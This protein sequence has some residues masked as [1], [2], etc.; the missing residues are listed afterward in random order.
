MDKLIHV[1]LSS[2]R[3]TSLSQRTT[4]ANLANVETVGFRAD[5]T[6]NFQAA[7]LA[8]AGEPTS[9]V[10]STAAP[11]SVSTRGG[12]LE[13]TGN[14]LDVAIN[15][16][17][18]L[19]VQAPDGSRVITRRGDLR[20]GPDQQLVNGSGEIVI[21]DNGPIVVPPYREISITNDGTVNI[22]PIDAEADAP[23]QSIGRLGLVAQPRGLRRR[24]DGNIEA[25]DGQ[26][27]PFDPSITVMSG[28]LER[29]NV[30]SVEVLGKMVELS[31][32]F[33]AQTKLLKTASNM[34]EI[35]TTLMRLPD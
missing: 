21:G 27:P 8:A 19:V 3:Q 11:Q 29:S 4:A 31:R 24:E 16:S 6:A 25:A 35:G 22:I 20:V 33:D 34:D 10:Y 28:Q 9:R 30:N 5:D 1:V 13:S 32:L 12:P 17:G 14:P 7:Y 18:Y 26:L 15:G 23:L 2:L